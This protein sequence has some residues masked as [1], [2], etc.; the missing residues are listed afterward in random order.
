MIAARMRSLLFAFSLLVAVTVLSACAPQPAIG[1]SDRQVTILFTHDLHSHLL[2]FPVASGGGPRVLRGGYARLATLIQRQRAVHGGGTLVVDAG[3]IAMGTLFHTIF[4]SDAAELR[5]MGVMGYDVITLG[6][7][8]FDFHADNLAK[9]LQ[10]AKASG[11]RLP[12]IVA[13]NYIIDHAGPRGRILA[14]AFTDFS[15]RDYVVLERGGLRIGLFGLMGKDA[16]EDVAFP[17]DVTFED[18][19]QVARR[20]ADLLRHKERVDLIVALSH[21]GTSPNPSRSEDEI[22]ARRVPEIDV[23]VSGHTHT[24]LPTPIVVGRTV[25][26]SS[27]SYGTHLG[28][29]DL[30]VAPGGPARVTGYHLAE[31]DAAVP[32][33]P[34]IAARVDAYEATVNRTFLAGYHLAFDQVIAETD[35]SLE[36]TGALYE[37]PGDS[38]L[39][40]FVTDA[41]RAAARGMGGTGDSIAIEP[42]G[43]IGDTLTRGPI[44]VDDAFRVL[45]RGLGSDGRIGYPLVAVYLTGAEIKRVLEVETTIAP[46]MK[47]DAHLQVSGIRFTFNP[48]RVPF[49][50][51]TSVALASSG[52]GYAPIEASRLYRVIVN[53]GVA[54][55]IGSIAAKSHGLIAAVPKDGEGRPLAN[56]EDAVVP[57]A[58]DAG[59]EASAK[60]WLALVGYL[61][62]LPDTN[63][64]G[65]PNIPE[66]YRQPQARFAAVPSWNPVDLVR[67]ATFVT[68]A[69]V[70]AVLLILAAAA[71]CAAA[72]TRRLRAA[73]GAAA[74]RT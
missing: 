20:V 11:E 17:H 54:Q 16:S 3:D 67:G 29:L 63:A 23:I 27:G 1:A 41:L 4:L 44:T 37:H 56:L 31:V 5:T 48:H 12:A 49:D 40:D 36:P 28:V 53:Y 64:N 55:L 52:G 2:P 65:I 35:F 38:G 70:V 47:E 26:V 69:V 7:H 39:G 50:R 45:S 66:Q 32:Q 33:D 30:D 51:V 18:P 71:W 6:N 43:I 42:I 34:T 22:L 74:A 73:R 60:E 58:A 10:R 72:L 13:S 46:L 59:G 25:I 57:W 21:S 8:E 68:Y 19:V 9:M 24:L 14:Q 61:R 62:A 15:V